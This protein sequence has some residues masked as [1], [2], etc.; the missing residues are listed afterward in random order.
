MS[1]DGPPDKLD[2]FE[3]L[4]RPYGIAELAAHR[5][6]RPAQARQRHHPRSGLARLVPPPDANMVPLLTTEV[7]TD[8]N[9]YYDKDADLASSPA[10]R[11][12]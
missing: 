10:A 1:L 8:G 3:E 4:L 9:V 11:S 5:P 7:K 12:P 6:G 2:D